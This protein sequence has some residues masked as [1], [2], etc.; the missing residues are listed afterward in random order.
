MK[1]LLLFI[2]VLCGLQGAAQQTLADSIASARGIYDSL[3]KAAQ[4]AKHTA[5]TTKPTDPAL[6]RKAKDIQSQAD[7]QKAHLDSM[8]KR[9]QTSTPLVPSDKKK[10]SDTA[11]KDCN[12]MP[13]YNPDWN[14]GGVGWW[15]VFTPLL[16]F[17]AIGVIV[18]IGLKAFN[19]KDALSEDNSSKVTIRNPEYTAANIGSPPLSDAPLSPAVMANLVTLIPPTIDITPVNDKNQPAPEYRPSISRLIAL[20]STLVIIIAVISMSSLFIYCYMSY[21]C[22]PDFSG[23]TGMLLALGLGIV[24]YTV[25]KAA[26]AA[27]DKK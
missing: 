19:I 10:V 12:C 18:G 4:V 11:G 3:I 25:N 27:A 5:D 20:L 16:I 15:L 2:F 24:P 14:K 9:P 17:I 21:G 1:K 7:K 22:P 13:V 23:F 8:V 26:N 6:D